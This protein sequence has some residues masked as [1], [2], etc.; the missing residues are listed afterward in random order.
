MQE[1]QRGEV[2]VVWWVVKGSHERWTMKEAGGM[3]VGDEEG[4]DEVTK[5]FGA[6]KTWWPIVVHEASCTNIS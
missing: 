2:G 5:E 6:W 4:L 3:R 1:A